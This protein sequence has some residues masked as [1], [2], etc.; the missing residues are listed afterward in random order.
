M[1]HREDNVVLA[2]NMKMIGNDSSRNKA[3]PKMLSAYFPHKT[4]RFH[5]NKGVK[6][7]WL[8][9]QVH[10]SKPCKL[11]FNKSNFSITSNQI[12]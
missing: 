4:P 5:I 12:A 6:S 7:T 9:F 2:P 10:Q 3:A 1:R 11:E 8:R